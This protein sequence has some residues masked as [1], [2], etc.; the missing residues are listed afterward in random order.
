MYTVK[1]IGAGSI[2]NHLAHAA[3]SKGWR[4]TLTDADPSALQR[5]RESIYPGRYGKWDDGIQLKDSA[6]AMTDPADIVFIGTPPDSHMKLANAVLDLTRPR[7]LMI[8]K[9]LCGPD[10][11]G[12]QALWQRANREGTFVGVGYNHV[13]GRNTEVAEEAL[14]RGIGAITTISTR[15]REHW[16]GIFKAHPWLSG[17]ADSYLG[18]YKRGGG[19]AGEHSHAINLWQHFAHVVGAGKVVDVSA[20]LDIVREGNTEYD[21]ICLLALRTTSG[22]TGDVIQDVVTAPMEKSAR[23]QGSDGY[24]HWHVN[25]QPN[26]DAVIASGGDAPAEPILISKTRADDFKAEM[27]H[28]EDV[29]NGKVANSPVAL[30]RGLDTMMVIAAA[31]KSH[32]S[33]RRVSIDWQ[34]GYTPDAIRGDS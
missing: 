26:V 28:L 9:P 27:N 17:P 10:L 5:T 23:I 16:G 7:A 12:C 2:G 18:F 19:A 32:Q 1:I 31:F 29:L 33:G 15:T 3:R 34:A 11:K 4:V 6:S 13:L 20:T 14:T 24:V 30:E 25:Y 8:E 22:L 21:R